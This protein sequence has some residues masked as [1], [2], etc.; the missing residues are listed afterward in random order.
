[1]KYFGILWLCE[2]SVKKIFNSENILVYLC[3]IK[4]V[5]IYFCVFME[6]MLKY[7]LKFYIF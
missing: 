3:K 4:D 1:M 6:L 7:F 2:L 5:Y